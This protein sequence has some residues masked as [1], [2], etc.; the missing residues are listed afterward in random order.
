MLLG[1]MLCSV[2]V[3]FG[4]DTP[5]SGWKRVAIIVVISRETFRW[6]SVEILFKCPD[7]KRFHYY[8]D[9][10]SKI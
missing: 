4:E 10:L 3:A 8:S 7:L 1:Y 2:A 5:Q 6:L 9:S